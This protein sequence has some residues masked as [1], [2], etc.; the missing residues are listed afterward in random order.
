MINNYS[1]NIYHALRNL[2]VPKEENKTKTSGLLSPVKSFI[3]KKESK[4]KKPVLIV[5]ESWDL[6]NNTRNKINGNNA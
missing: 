6:L 1:K 3:R 4:N 2:Q 5:K